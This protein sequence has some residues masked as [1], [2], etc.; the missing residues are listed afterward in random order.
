MR[1]SK[2]V[3]VMYSSRSEGLLDFFYPEPHSVRSAKFVVNVY[4][5]VYNV[6]KVK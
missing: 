1:Y 6:Y 2:P 3:N 5:N 4:K